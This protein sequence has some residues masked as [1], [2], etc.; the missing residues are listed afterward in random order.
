MYARFVA[1]RR[2]TSLVGPLKTEAE[3]QLQNLACLRSCA[4]RAASLLLDTLLLS[5]NLQRMDSEFASAM[6]YRLGLT[7]TPAN[8]LDVQCWCGQHLEPGDASHMVTCTSLSG[9]MTV[10]PDIPRGIWRRIDS[11]ARPFTCLEPL[12]H[13]LLSSQA[14]AI[15]WHR[16]GSKHQPRDGWAGGIGRVNN[17]SID[18]ESASYSILLPLGPTMKVHIK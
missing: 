18:N 6:R 9:V 3:N 2:H 4:C 14:A 5:V 1:Q 8:A 13:L 12:L 10:R 15:A 7:H 11:R 16:P 17:E